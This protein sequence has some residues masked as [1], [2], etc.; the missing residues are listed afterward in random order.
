L[1]FSSGDKKATVKL[2]KPRC[3]LMN[4]SDQLGMFKAAFKNSGLCLV[5]YIVNP[6]KT[7]PSGEPIKNGLL[8]HFPTLRKDDGM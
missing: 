6:Y 4:I 7:G 2:R 3:P 1:P 5:L 8:G